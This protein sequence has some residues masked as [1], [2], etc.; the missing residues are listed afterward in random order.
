MT[1]RFRLTVAGT[2]ATTL[3][4]ATPAV[5]ATP[6]TEG[7]YTWTVEKGHALACTGEGGGVR[8]SV[9]L[10]ENSAFGT[11][12]QVFVQ[13]AETE[14][15]RGGETAGGLF[16]DGRIRRRLV[17]APQEPA[18]QERTAKSSRTVLVSGSYAPSGPR[19]WVHEVY[20]E[21]SGQV[22]SKGWNT[23]LSATVTVN[24]LGRRIGLTCETAFAY[25]LKVRRPADSGN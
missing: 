2:L 8:V 14:Y 13:T 12:A 24:T 21:P 19:R 25:D 18:A 15:V 17:V 7:P 5:A 9:D 4:S 6:G 16:D 22:V 11:H 20:D 1:H 10:Y 3:L 23:P